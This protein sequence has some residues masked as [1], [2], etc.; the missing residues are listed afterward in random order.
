MPDVVDRLE[1]LARHIAPPDV[2]LADAVMARI[3]AGQPGAALRMR[4]RLPRRALVLA[5]AAAVVVAVVLAVPPSRRAV[6]RWFGIGAVRFDEVPT[7]PADLGPTLRLGPEVALDDLKQAVLAPPALGRPAKAFAG[8]PAPDA[9]TLVWGPANG[10]PEVDG[11]GAGMLLSQFGGSVDATRVAKLLAPGTSVEAVTVGGNPGFWITGAPHAFVFL[12]PLG[13]VRE[14]TT[15]LVG[16]NTLLWV[17]DGV[18]FR[19]ECGLDL[20]AT[21]ELAESLQPLRE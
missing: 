21:L 13:D 10:L 6:A 5:I 16:G 11:T 1:D 20:D 8:E 18:T 9:V 12:D 19:M 4:P 14:D 7:L 3:R 17:Q 15:R 2:D